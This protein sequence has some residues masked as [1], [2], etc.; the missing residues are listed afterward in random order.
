MILLLLIIIFN[1]VWLIRFDSIPSCTLY[2]GF[3]NDIDKRSQKWM[4]VVW[5]LWTLS[6]TV[7]LLSCCKRQEILFPLGS[8]TGLLWNGRLILNAELKLLKKATQEWHLTLSCKVWFPWLNWWV[9][10]IVYGNPII[11]HHNIPQSSQS[12][13]HTSTHNF[14]FGIEHRKK[15]SQKNYHCG[16]I[17][18]EFLILVMDHPYWKILRAPV[19]NHDKIVI[20]DTVYCQG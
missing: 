11:I 6:I 9:T 18:T 8:R 20:G 7:G 13:S 10:N 19:N 1:K 4:T 14:A 15:T 3:G 17:Q 5:N 16:T 2:E 12:V